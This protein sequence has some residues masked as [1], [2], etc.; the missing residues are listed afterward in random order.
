MSGFTATCPKGHQITGLIQAAF[1]GIEIERFSEKRMP[2]YANV[3]KE[4]QILVNARAFG[5]RRSDKTRIIDDTDLG[6]LYICAGRCD[7]L[8]YDDLIFEEE[9]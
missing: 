5:E 3:Q 8:T 4:E 9:R 6:A 1:M 2:I 7:H